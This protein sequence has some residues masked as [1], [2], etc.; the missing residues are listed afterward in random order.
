MA[1]FKR[2]SRSRRF[3][4]FKRKGRSQSS[5]KPTQI[6]VG[7]AI[8]GVGRTYLSNMIAPIT[9]KVPFGNLA[10]NVVL[11][12]IGYFAAKKGRGLIKQ[13][14]ISALAVESALAGQD[15]VGSGLNQTSGGW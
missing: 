7:G 9:S 15:L 13:V 11:G 8:Y 3:S 10:D 6:M 12:A 14:G 2:K 1:R 4:F 5:L